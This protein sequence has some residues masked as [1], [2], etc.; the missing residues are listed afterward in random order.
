MCNVRLKF[1]GLSQILG[2]DNLVLAVLV[3]V[4]EQRQLV[5]PC[6]RHQAYQIR[7]RMDPNML[8]ERN[9]LLPEVLAEL[10]PFSF[11]LTYRFEIY[12]LHEGK[13]MSCLRNTETGEK[14]NIRCT[15]GILLSLIT[16]MEIY[17]DRG[18]MTKQSAEYNPNFTQ[19]AV[20]VNVITDKMLEESLRKAIENE[21]YE[22]ASSLRD[23]LK[24]RH[25]KGDKPETNS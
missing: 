15:D 7:L 5:I 4:A 24:K 20:P 14:K 13:Y 22:L 18:L 1:K 21:N 10:M 8:K 23:E 3:D 16:G 11:L 12:A 17:A 6:D 19:M 9:D 25:P 2:S